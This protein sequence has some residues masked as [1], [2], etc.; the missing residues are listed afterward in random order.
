MRGKR[1]R[2]IKII[3]KDIITSYTRTLVVDMDFLLE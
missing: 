1:R 2:K 3:K